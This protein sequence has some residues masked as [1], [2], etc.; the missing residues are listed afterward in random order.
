MRSSTLPIWR[1]WLEMWFMG[2][3]AH[4]D[5]LSD[6]MHSLEDVRT[7]VAVNGRPASRWNDFRGRV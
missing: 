4:L 6:L 3:L 2:G 7:R 1:Y 5:R